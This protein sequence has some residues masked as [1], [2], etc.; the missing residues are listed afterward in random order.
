VQL[1]CDLYAPERRVEF[2]LA[3]RFRHLPPP[4]G[5]P[6]S[7]FLKTGRWWQRVVRSP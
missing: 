5:V 7:Y 3:V 1:G 2:I 6:L 4:G